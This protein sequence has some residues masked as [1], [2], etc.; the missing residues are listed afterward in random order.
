MLSYSIAIRTLGT[1]GEKFREELLSITYQTVQPERVLVYIAEGYARPT[2][3]VGQ[4]EYIW[5]KKGMV[6]QRILPYAEI[7]SDVIFMLDDDVRLAPDSAERMLKAIE[8]YQAD[9]VGADTFKNHNMPVVKKIYAAL[10]NL[11][12]PHWSD[13]WAFKIH[14][15]GSFSYNNYPTKN[16]YWSQSCAGNA[17]MLRI[18]VY[19]QL[20]FE[21]EMWL[22]DLPFAYNDDMVE[23]YKIYKNGFRLGVL[24][25]AG[26][27]HLNGCSA[28]ATFRKGSQWVYTRTKAM[29]I[30]WWRMIYQTMPK[31]SLN[32]L[33]VAF[34]FIIKVTWLF[35][36]MC[37]VSVMKFMPQHVISY[38]NGLRAGWRFVHTV[39]FQ[40][41][42]NYVFCNN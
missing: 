41:L 12:F 14:H 26:C 27:E 11:V 15:N 22:D 1:A 36:V 4:E 32:K 39:K 3:T 24:Y 42:R 28:S 34:Y 33:F 23:S 5:E 13:K 19:R 40:S 6:A 8:E 25:D 30:I 2:F 21:D 9:C 29:F 31:N 20:H 17:V 10:T 37:S 16:F 35:G 38:I 18:S 7:T